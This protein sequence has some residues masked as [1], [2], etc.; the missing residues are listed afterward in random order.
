MNDKGNDIFIVNGH[1][2]GPEHHPDD[3]APAPF[4]L[5]A[6]TDTLLLA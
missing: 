6:Q 3:N 1:K 4:L 5:P 2:K